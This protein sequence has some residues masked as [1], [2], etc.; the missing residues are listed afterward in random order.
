MQ[1]QQHVIKVGTNSF[2]SLHL[3]TTELAYPNRMWT[4]ADHISSKDLSREYNLLDCQTCR[5][6][7]LFAS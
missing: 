3:T 6:C 2:A 1:Q 4:A 5:Y 7:L